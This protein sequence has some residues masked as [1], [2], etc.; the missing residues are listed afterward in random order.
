MNDEDLCLKAAT[1]AGTGERVCYGPAAEAVIWFESRWGGLEQ[2]DKVAMYLAITR[3]RA[4]AG[5][6]THA[7]ARLKA[8]GWWRQHHPEFPIEIGG[9]RDE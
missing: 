5:G 2:N 6:Q 1:I 9:A 3:D 8:K 7:E 4:M